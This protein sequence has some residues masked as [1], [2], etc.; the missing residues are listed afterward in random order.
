MSDLIFKLSPTQDKFIFSD[1]IVNLIYSSKGEGKSLDLLEKVI[2]A[3]GSIRFA[4]D[5]KEGDQLMGDDSLQRNVLSIHYGMDDMYEIIPVKGESF[6]C[7]KEHILVLDGKNFGEGETHIAVKDYLN[8]PDWYKS[9][10]LLIR[11]GI[12]FSAQPVAIEPYFLGAWIADGHSHALAVTTMDKEVVDYL[13]GFAAKWDTGITIYHK[14][15]SKAKSY[16]LTNGSA[17]KGEHLPDR[18]LLNVFK[19]LNL[20]HNKHIPDIYKYNSREVRLELLAGLMDGDGF[21]NHEGYDYV[22]KYKQ[23]ADD[24]V[25]LC[26]SLELAAYVKKCTKGIKK[27]GFIG[28]YYRIHISGDCSIIPV[29]IERRKCKPRKQIKRVNVTGIKEVKSLGRGKYIGWVLDGD[30]KYLLGSFIVSHNTFGSVA[31]MIHHARRCKKDIR[32]AIVRDTHT[33][34]KI[35]TARSIQDALPLGSYKFKDD[36]KFLTIF[37]EPKV[38]IDLF[39]IDDTN[40]V[41][42]LQGPEYA[43]IWLEEPAPI[44]D[45]DNAGLSEDVFNAALASC[46]RQTK[47]KPRLQI[48][49]NPGNTDHWTHRRLLAGLEK[50][51]DGFYI[52]D[53][54]NP[55]ITLSVFRMPIGENK[56]L[57]KLA[58]QATAAA[59]QNDA[60]S[61][62]RYVK[63]EFAKVY[64]GKRVAP[65]YNKDGRHYSE[66]ELI[67]ASGLVGFRFW[68][69]W[70]N[71]SCCIGQITHTGRL[72]FI[73]TCR[74]LQSDIRTL[75]RTQVNPLLNSPKWRGKCKAWRDGGDFSMRQADQSNKQESAMKVIEDRFGTIFE[76][77]PHKWSFMKDGITKALNES[78]KGLPALVVSHNN[79]LLHDALMGGWHYKTDKAGNIASDVPMKTEESHIGDAFANAVNVLLPGF[80]VKMSSK[81]WN[82]ISRRIKDRVASYG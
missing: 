59:Y 20:F 37:S 28:E 69:S 36:Y 29:K 71:P 7:N 58:R 44:A 50:N 47:T 79:M 62:A 17:A 65:D 55:L 24:I 18:K 31:A 48:S 1:A 6:K 74:V 57:S 15:N 77:G 41:S 33:N 30:H 5:V 2:M 64:R 16:Y 38:E 25:Y 76:S 63:G 68:D 14:S 13:Y 78:I 12:N 10:H 8:K 49:M 3:D 72:V 4:K 70:A 35:S 82:T 9:H 61:Y 45:A 42:K 52:L 67:P 27:T 34:I 60:Q 26:R 21:I 75:I 56:N 46:A 39:G 66:V 23:L 54:L 40:A 11:R 73:D 43:I 80:T 32:G 81:K 51:E 22:T 53:P 19:G